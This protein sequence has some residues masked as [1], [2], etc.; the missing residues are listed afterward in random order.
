MSERPD[1]PPRFTVVGGPNGVGKSTFV[2]TLQV[3]RREYQRQRVALREEHKRA[4]TACAPYVGFLNRPLQAW[5]W[6]KSITTGAV[7]S[8]C[9]IM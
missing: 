9:S 7:C 2:A 1:S 5:A 6:T 8:G 3:A 4:W